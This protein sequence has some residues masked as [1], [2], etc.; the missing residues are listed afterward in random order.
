MK[1][2]ILLSL[3]VI[4]GITLFATESGEKGAWKRHNDSLSIGFKL[5]E[6][7][8]NLGINLDLVSPTF[9][10]FFNARVS[11]GYIMEKPG[12][13]S[14]HNKYLFGLRGYGAPV[15]DFLKLYGEFGGVL[16]QEKNN[17]EAGI[18]GLFGFEFFT[19]TDYKSPVSYFIELGT[20]GLAE[21]LYNGFTTNVGFRYYF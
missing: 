1:K 4:T 16:I 12:F 10:R 6:I 8:D 13:E 3:L 11:A 7:N 21:D 18:Y 9:L 15:T 20:N 5:E 17:F 2:I 14:T 19:A